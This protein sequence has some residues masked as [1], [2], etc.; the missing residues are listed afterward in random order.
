MY[1]PCCT[2]HVKLVNKESVDTVKAPAAITEF[3]YEMVESKVKAPVN[4]SKVYR[5]TP[6]IVRIA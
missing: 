5:S 3:A 2:E 1:L 4:V 6:G